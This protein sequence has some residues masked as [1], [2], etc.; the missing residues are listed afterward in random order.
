MET[1]LICDDERDI[2]SAL[3]IY[4]RAEGWQ[5]VC[6]YSGREAVQI[7]QTQNIQLILMDIMMPEMDGIETL[8]KIR[9]E[10]NKI[11][12]KTPIIAFTANALS[13]VKEKYIGEGFTDYLSKPIRAK[14]LAEMLMRHLP[15][16]T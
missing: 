16:G 11:D 1:I 5:T 7:A 14:D 8:H 3:N 12:D 4:L 13:G 10:D 15:D 6:A 2:V 9:E